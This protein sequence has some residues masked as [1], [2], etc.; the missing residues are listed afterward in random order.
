MNVARP[1]IILLRHA[2]AGLVALG[3][4]WGDD[5]SAQA[6]AVPDWETTKAYTALRAH[7]RLFVT[8]RRLARAVEG[9]GADFAAQVAAIERAAA[10]ALED[11]AP[12]MPA[13][14]PFDRGFKIQGRLGALAV[15]WHRTGD[16]RYLEAALNTLEGMKP[17]LQPMGEYSLRHGQYIAGVALCIDLLYDDLTGEEKEFVVRF[18]RDYCIRPFLQRT[19]RGRT[20]AEHGERG[21]WWQHIASNWNPVCVSGPGML[22]LVLYEDLAEAQTVLDRVD[23]SLQA[24][25]DYVE[26]AEGGWMEGLGY[27][28]WTLHYCV[29]YWM[30]RENAAGEPVAAFRSD[31]I[32]ACLRFGERF[33]AHGEV[34]GFGDNNH[35]GVGASLLAAAEHLG[36]PEVLLRLQAHRA[37]A[38]RAVAHK[39]AL[40]AE[41]QGE[42]AAVAARD[43]G[44]D[45]SYTPVHELLILPDPVDE[46]P[47]IP[48][49]VHPVHHYPVQ[50]WG[51]LA[52]RWPEP[53]VYASVRGGELGGP[54][55]HA[56]LLSWNVV[57]GI[58]KM[59]TTVNKAGYYDT[60][61]Q[62]RALEIY[63]RNAASENTLFIGGLS[64][65]NG[66]RLGRTARAT[67]SSWIT[68][69]GPALRLDATR[70]FWLTRRSPRLVAR[71]F[72]VLDD[73]GLL[74]LDRIVGRGANPVEARMHTTQETVWGDRHVV[75]NGT[76]ETARLTL[77]CNRP[78]VLRRATALLTDARAEPPTVI[79]WQTRD[80][81]QDVTLATLLTRGRDA[82]DLEL[83]AGADEVRVSAS[84]PGW[85]AGVTLDGAL[86]PLSAAGE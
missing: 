19:G 18:A 6:P 74:V 2:L 58:E 4:V 28:N 53:A 63:E 30:S 17:W 39:D 52:D 77:A 83:I 71:V 61:W 12:L 45:I 55:T 46:P 40:R 29:L 48:V 70:A 22:A 33:V 41:A 73:R 10:F 37:R 85:E 11:M 43:E 62:Q 60:A 42:A 76:F 66:T 47:A 78:A 15:Q 1:G 5:V 20:M 35:A 31:G 80:S 82:V 64:A 27:W 56:D 16:R 49:E 69:T 7:P 38:A 13:H 44:V 65:Y 54:H 25:V 50:G 34:C 9:R 32:R 81:V 75:L 67:A 59:I 68:P 8:P 57:L 86:L 72:V 26:R 23:A 14:S 3:C 51:M 24:V 21:S 36:R 84:S 79:R